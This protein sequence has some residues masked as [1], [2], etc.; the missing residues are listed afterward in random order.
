VDKPLREMNMGIIKTDF[1]SIYKC[2]SNVVCDRCFDWRKAKLRKNLHIN[3][4]EYINAHK[5]SVT[6]LNY[7]LSVYYSNID[8]Q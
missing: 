3:K 7:H 4:S 5:K 2:N 8:F 6:S 1:M